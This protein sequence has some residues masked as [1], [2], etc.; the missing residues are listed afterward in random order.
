MDLLNYEGDNDTIYT[1]MIIMT[2]WII[3]LLSD[4]YSTELEDLDAYQMDLDRTITNNVITFA[5]RGG[6]TCQHHGT[7]PH[8]FHSTLYI[9]PYFSLLLSL[10]R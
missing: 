4:C 1:M 7:T 8:T 6:T 5:S 2:L 9:L 3:Y 10:L